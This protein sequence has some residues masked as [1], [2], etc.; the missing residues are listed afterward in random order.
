MAVNFKELDDGTLVELVQHPYD[1][2]R[3][4][5][6][7]WKD[8][9]FRYEEKLE[10]AGRI[11]VPMPRC[12][13]ILK[14]I[15]LPQRPEPYQSIRDLARSIF[16]FLNRYVAL[17]R[18]YLVVLTAFVLSTWISDRLPVAPYISLVGLPQS[19]KTTLL[20]TLNLIC[21]RPLLIADASIAVIYQVYAQLTPTLLIDE[22]AS[23]TEAAALRRLLRTG[24]TRDVIM[25]RG[26]EALHPYGPKVIFWIEPPNDSALYSRSFQIPMLEERKRVADLSDATTAKLADNLQGQLLRFRLENYSKI[27]IAKFSKIERLR[28]RGRDILNALA[29]PLICN[30]LALEIT[31]QPGCR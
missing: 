6:G 15:R 31:V 21:R 29:A 17:N 4:L 3:T 30:G 10:Y 20:R 1:P 11:L 27:K 2:H 19:G 13:D 26:K 9:T 28:P 8:R 7:L 12:S 5:F 14:R 25:V 22:A 16:D 18:E 24:T 23:F